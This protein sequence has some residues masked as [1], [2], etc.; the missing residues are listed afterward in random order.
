MNQRS[1]MIWLNITRLARMQTSHTN[2]TLL[3]NSTAWRGNPILKL[4][5]TNSTVGKASRQATPAL[6][7]RRRRSMQISGR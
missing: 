4:P 2:S 3:S 6:I 1:R 7:S 5:F